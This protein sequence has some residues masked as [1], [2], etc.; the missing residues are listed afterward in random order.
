MKGSLLGNCSRPRTRRPMNKAIN[1]R[2]TSAEKAICAKSRAVM[3]VVKISEIVK[4]D[5][6]GVAEGIDAVEHPAVAGD[7]SAKVLDAKIAF[8]RA[9]HRAAE[10]AGQR[11]QESDADA[12]QRRERS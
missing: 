2:S 1:G 5:R 4:E 10:K 12:F 3:S 9:H 6:A 7:Q 8:Y 11:Q